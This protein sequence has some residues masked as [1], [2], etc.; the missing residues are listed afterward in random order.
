MAEPKTSTDQ[1]APVKDTKRYMD[2]KGGA[3]TYKPGR[4]HEAAEGP[5]Y[6]EIRHGAE[7]GNEA[8][9]QEAGARMRRQAEG[10]Q[11]QDRG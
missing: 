1:Y 7:V 4:K 6:Q 5:A 9:R 3:G 8:R 10:E 11:G 2:S